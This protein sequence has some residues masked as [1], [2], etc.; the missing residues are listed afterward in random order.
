MG[1]PSCAGCPILRP[2]RR[3]GD[4]LVSGTRS[5]HRIGPP[6]LLRKDG[7][8]GRFSNGCPS[9][10][11]RRMVGDGLVPGTRS[12]LES[13]PHPCCARM[14]HPRVFQMGAPVFA[15]GEWWGTDLCR[16]LGPSSN[17]S[18]TLAA[19]GWGTRAFFKWVPHS[20]TKSKGG[21]RSL[22]APFFTVDEG[23]R[24][25]SCDPQRPERE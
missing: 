24:I 10:R 5:F 4:G 16:A 2:R 17:R 6:P 19:Q 25:F 20:S 15:P 21:G 13:V 7:A 3:V 18:P 11:P 9:L 12:F 22:D 23:S 1:A 14:G 8:P